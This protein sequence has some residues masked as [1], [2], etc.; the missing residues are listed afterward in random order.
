MEDAA[1]E[2]EEVV[3]RYVGPLVLLALVWP[4]NLYGLRRDLEWEATQ[5]GQV[6]AARINWKAQPAMTRQE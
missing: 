1:A 5:D 4:L 2:G 6:L 3:L